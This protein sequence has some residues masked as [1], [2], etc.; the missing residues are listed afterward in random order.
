MDEGYPDSGKRSAA[1]II[2]SRTHRT[3]L[4]WIYEYGCF[5]PVIA[6]AVVS[7]SCGI[8]NGLEAAT[9]IMLMRYKQWVGSGAFR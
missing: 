4:A 1:P 2:A 9:L 5:P 8:S 6:G 7:G 3:I